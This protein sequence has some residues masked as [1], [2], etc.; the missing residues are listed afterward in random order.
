MGVKTFSTVV[1]GTP[2]PTYGTLYLANLD[3]SVNRVFQN[4]S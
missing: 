1:H 2:I 4:A 3:Y